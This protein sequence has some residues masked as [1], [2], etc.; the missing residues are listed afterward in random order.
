MVRGVF[1][2]FKEGDKL[3]YWTVV[4]PVEEKL[5]KKYWLVKCICGKEKEVVQDALST[6]RSKSCGCRRGRDLTGEVFGN[7]TVVMKVVRGDNVR[8]WACE[9]VCGNQTVVRAQ[10]LIKGDTR[11]CGCL[12]FGE[13]FRRESGGV[14]I[15]NKY[16]SYKKLAKKRGQEFK[17][18]RVE[19]GNLLIAN[20]HCCGVEPN[21]KVMKNKSVIL[22]INDISR[23]DP[24]KG[25]TSDNT[26]TF[27]KICKMIKSNLT[28]EEFQSWLYRLFTQVK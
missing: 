21:T 22:K 17:L 19:F 10:S 24:N 27:C 3:H 2:K 12:G 1:L 15:T 7:L 25:Y 26:V 5:G 23:I 11:S 13:V 16:K 28:Q 4:A 14:A 20:C 6:G 18:S 9:C 8:G